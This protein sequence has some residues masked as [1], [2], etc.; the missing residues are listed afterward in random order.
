[1]NLI[2][3]LIFLLV[4]AL[5]GIATYIYLGVYDVSA[6][7]PHS[8]FVYNVME[9]TRQ[10]SIAARAADVRVPPLEDSAMIAGG[11]E[12]YRAMCAGCHLAPGVAD[13]E[14]RTGLYPQP[15]NLSQPLNATPAE[16]FW[17]IK[18]GIKMSAMPA[19]G[20]SHDDK[21]IWAIVAFVQKLPGMTPAQYE[22]MISA[23]QG[24]A[25]H[26]H[27]DPA[28]GPG[29]AEPHADAGPGEETAD[30]EH[31]GAPDSA[32]AGGEPSTPK[33]P[34]SFE[35]LKPDAVPEAEQ[36]AMAFHRAMDTGD[37]EA[38]LSLLSADVT[39][40]EAGST[41]SRDEYAS[42]RLGED[43][44]SVKNT[45]VKHLSI[46]SMLTGDTALVGSESEFRTG[47]D[48]QPKLQRNRELLTLKHENGSWKIV[49]IRSQTFPMLPSDAAANDLHR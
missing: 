4:L 41:L 35:G 27:D 12:H 37:R 44:A 23:G 3:T 18:H 2:R 33:T 8:A 43:I 45:Q 36:V 40:N 49:T 48:A 19:W 30:H 26:H 14:L 20:T 38:A 22:A 42:A 11:A 7:V 5:I 32:L 9:L 39:V 34:L 13:S 47:S 10:R 25:S 29:A 21:A 6:D 1:M 31:E 28:D 15:P 17:A 24:E 16:M 46:A